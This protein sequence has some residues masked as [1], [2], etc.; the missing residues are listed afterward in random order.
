MV[1]SIE[2]LTMLESGKI[3]VESSSQ[4]IV[5]HCTM[6]HVIHNL[7]LDLATLIV[8]VIASFIQVTDN[9]NCKTILF[10][11]RSH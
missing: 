3:I 9:T 4:A 1:V 8:I 6:F 5:S 7:P 10:G 11:I 2:L